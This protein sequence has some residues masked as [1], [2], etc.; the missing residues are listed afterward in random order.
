VNDR[1]GLGNYW[2]SGR[3][4]EDLFDP[5]LPTISD[6]QIRAIADSYDDGR[7]DTLVEAYI[8]L[9]KRI[10]SAVKVLDLEDE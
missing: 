3:G 4:S 9:R 1:D 8:K 10:I 7:I 5:L 6:Q 2:L